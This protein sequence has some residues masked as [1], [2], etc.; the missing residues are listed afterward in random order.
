MTSASLFKDEL[1]INEQLYQMHLD[2]LDAQ[3]EGYSA[4]EFFGNEPKEMAD[5]ILEQLPKT[6]IRTLFEYTGIAAIVVWS[7]RLIF[8][9]NNTVEVMINPALYIFD[10][11]LVIGLILLIFNSI[12][13]SV[14]KKSSKN[15]FGL[16]EALI[17]GLLLVAF[18]VIYLTSDRFIPNI[19]A[20][21][22]PFPL[23][24]LIILSVSLAIILFILK[25][26]DQNFYFL[27][28]TFAI[29]S[30]IGIDKRLEVHTN[31]EI[32]FVLKIVLLLM[33]G[34]AFLY[35]KKRVN[36]T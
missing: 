19:F 31:F 30:M 8:D 2:F 25:T 5:R 11:V 21:T 26:K 10:L 34:I 32:P 16:L 3:D 22:I 9:F 24:I 14:Y 20:F 15:K 23:D 27:A 28:L 4:E 18:I 36:K 13:S 1:A 7:I 6:S 12:Q 29:A 33:L 17:A 35:L